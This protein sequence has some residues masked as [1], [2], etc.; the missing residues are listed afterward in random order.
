MTI[1]VDESNNIFLNWDP[2]VGANSYKIYGAEDPYAVFVNIGSC[3]VN[4]YQ[5]SGSEAKEFFYVVASTDN[6]K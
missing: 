3:A 6:L 2:V 4:Q 1:S 5:Y